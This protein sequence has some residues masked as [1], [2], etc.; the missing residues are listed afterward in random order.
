MQ[1]LALRPSIS[2]ERACPSF[3]EQ[4]F[5]KEE[6]PCDRSV[7]R[8]WQVQ[9]LELEGLTRSVIALCCSSHGGSGAGT[10]NSVGSYKPKQENEVG[11][12]AHQ[13]LESLDCALDY[14]W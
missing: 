2:Y 5:Y 6:L 9:R 11:Q 14:K 10:G 3:G 13:T 4:I 8:Q 1:T 7:C 12:R